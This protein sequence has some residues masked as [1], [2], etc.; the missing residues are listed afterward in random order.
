M[1]R[2]PSVIAAAAPAGPQ[3][4]TATRSGFT[5]SVCREPGC[6]RH[7]GVVA[8]R[9][10]RGERA[11]LS[12]RFGGGSG[13]RLELEDNEDLV[14]VRSV[15]RGARHDVSPLS[16]PSRTAQDR[17]TPLFGFPEAGV[18]VYAAHEGDAPDIAVV[19]NED[20]EV[21]FAGRG[22]RDQFGAPVVYTENVFV[23]FRD[24]LPPARCEALL[25]EAGLTVKRLTGS[26]PN[27]YFA[28]APAGIGREVF[29]LAERLLDR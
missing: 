18:G 28:G 14:V 16:S 5:S 7:G 12:C 15:R 17:L 2:A 13:F 27:A 6:R 21:E 29:P 19:L 22:L 24:D 26:A 25:A 3:P 11:M 8:W 9:P 20:P 10:S 1:P 23:K 4:S